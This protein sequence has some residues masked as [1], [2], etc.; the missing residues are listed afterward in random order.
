MALDIQPLTPG[1]LDDLAELFGQ[2]GDPK[3]CWCAYF[4]V[5]GRDWT[6]S[7]AADN[8]AVL[9]R[10]VD[11][12]AVED[13][14]PG[15]VA[16]DGD[17]AVGWVSL[18]PREDYERLAFS[19]VLAPIDDTPVWSIVCFVVGRRSRGKG[20]ANAMLDAA[21]AEARTH[22]ATMLEAYPVELE[23]GQRIPSANVYH[24][25]LSMFERAGFEVVERRQWSAS[26]PV[27]PIVRLRL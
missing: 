14:A 13:R 2:G 16:Y 10:A 20:V 19:K 23:D 24:G 9:E 4:R 22:G 3:W 12:A 8:R 27:R 15:L 7:T 18:G 21:I 11:E 25:T 6:N 26:S 5:R 1:R 17:A